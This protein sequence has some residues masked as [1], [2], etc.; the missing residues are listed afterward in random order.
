MFGEGIDVAEKPGASRQAP[1]A[2]GSQKDLK[3]PC[4]AYIAAKMQL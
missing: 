4:G 3:K 1:E 2:G